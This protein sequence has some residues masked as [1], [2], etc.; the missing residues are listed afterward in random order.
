MPFSLP[1]AVKSSNLGSDGADAW[2]LPTAAA[3]YEYI[4][5]VMAAQEMRITPAAGDKINHAGTL[6]D[7]AE[8]YYADAVGEIL[9]II[10]VDETNW[11]VISQT[12]TWAEQNP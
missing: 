8:Y 12:G 6:G 1:K 11:V 10:A 3:G 9:H 5:V 7:A 4:F 2:T